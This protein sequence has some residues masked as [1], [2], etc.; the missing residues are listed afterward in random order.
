MTAASDSAPTTS[1]AGSGTI[2]LVAAAIGAPLGVFALALLAA[3]HEL[4]HLV[5]HSVPQSLGQHHGP[6]WWYVL[7]VPI[8]GGALA[9][10]SLV[11]SG[12]PAEGH[13]SMQPVSLRVLPLLLTGAFLTLVCGFVVGPEAPMIATA[14]A[15]AAFA[16]RLGGITHEPTLLVVTAAGAFTV[17]STLL[18]SP[19]VALVLMIEI[20]AATG[21]VPSQRLVPLFLPGL[22]AASLGLLVFTGIAGWTGVT[23]PTF[24]LPDLPRYDSIRPIDVLWCVPVALVVAFGVEAVQLA[25]A[26]LR[27]VVRVR[28][29]VAT[30][31]LGALVGTCGLG[32]RALADRPIDDV[33]FS[34]QQ[35]LP[36]YV[37]IA[38]AGT[39][40]LVIAF[41]AVAYAASLA[42][43]VEGGPI[44]PVLALAGATGLAAA[45]LLPGA[46]V[47]PMVA[48][49]IA[50]GAAALQ[51][52]PVFG[53]TF[54]LLLIGSSAAL[55]ATLF[56]VVGA[57]IG[58]VVATRIAPGVRAKR[59]PAAEQQPATT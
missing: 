52:L 48:A 55:E 19:I 53:M 21:A 13:L 20:V 35:A 17:L 45:D 39:L 37:T 44:F 38:S 14:V 4:T 6:A 50:A 18:V 42:A 51:K 28:P 27:R 54:A 49:A 58:D 1:S 31:A 3:V 16:G 30:A 9:A 46:A 24:A 7:A 43:R 56:C 11:R 5:W 26:A 34:G 25:A 10:A 23:A 33:L 57:L 8:L 47:V 22:L 15:L 41:K 32:Y 40:S 12:A 2:W 59:G 29:V 36:E